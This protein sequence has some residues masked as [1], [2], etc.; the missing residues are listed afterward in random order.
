[1]AWFEYWRPT[2]AYA[3]RRL[4]LI[5]D[6]ARHDLEVI[7]NSKHRCVESTCHVVLEGC[8]ILHARMGVTRRFRVPKSVDLTCGSRDDHEATFDD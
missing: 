3:Q 5:P 4:H 1:M 7:E 2:C 6:S 8:C